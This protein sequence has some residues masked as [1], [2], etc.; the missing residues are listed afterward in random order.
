[1]PDVKTWRLIDGD[2]EAT[3]PLRAEEIT[4]R[5]W[6]GASE[7]SWAEPQQAGDADFA[8]DV[9]EV[10]RLLLAEPDRVARAALRHAGADSLEW[11]FVWVAETLAHHTD[12]AWPLLL[13]LI[14]ASRGY[15]DLSVIAAGPLG[16]LLATQGA[17]VIDRI[18]E[19]AARDARVR[20]ALLG[21][22]PADI[23]EAIWKRVT[24]ARG[25]DPGL[26]E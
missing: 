16:D 23:D 9:P 4:A 17:R 14:E 15:E 13:S 21:V 3:Q 22:G 6:S 5:L 11:M 12:E 2:G 26:G 1:M 18:E 10:R 25:T 20:R 24:T 7:L 19:W 8:P